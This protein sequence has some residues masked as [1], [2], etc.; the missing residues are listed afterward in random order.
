MTTP[1]SFGPQ[2]P[3]GNPGQPPY[4]P[5][6]SPSAAGQPGFG[7]A[8]PQP[9]F[10]PPSG[11]QPSSQPSYGQVPPGQPAFGQ[12]GP[13]QPGGQAPYGGP[14]GGAQPPAKKS[15]L[16]LLI[17]G[18]VAGVLVLALVAV[19][20]VPRLVGSNSERA[21][22]LAED[23]LTA[24]SAGKATE[25]RG[26]LESAPSDT[27]LLTDEVLAESVKKAPITE[28]K[29]SAPTSTT[30]DSSA[31][32]VP[33][34][35]KIGS[36][37]VTDSVKVVVN[38][39]KLSVRE[40]TVTL[41]LPSDVKGLTVLVNG[42]K[43]GDS[44]AVFPGT[45][46]VTTQEKY[47]T[48]GEK[49]TV[50]V[51]STALNRVRFTGS[52]SLSEEGTTIFR[53]KIIA[54]AEECLKSTQLKAGC[55]LDVPNVVSGKTMKEGSVTRSLSAEGRAT[56]ESLEPQLGSSRAYVVTVKGSMPAVETRVEATD[57]GSGTVTGGA[58]RFDKPSIDFSKEDLPI[59]WS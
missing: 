58:A 37:Q 30:R 27:S 49:G 54:A 55:G 34:T 13:G 44:P 36:K 20:V 3:F 31:F 22:K 9:P 12:P 14:S 33:V 11:S 29:A 15:K 8:A 48:F 56:L 6:G 57:G 7:P 46:T 18:G 25:A 32:T 39:A 43:P 53:E 5:G 50:V 21:R 59:T 40:G 52:P 35:Y 41:S 19:L 16:P 38:D 47:F 4:G 2:S 42:V 17:G 23:Y 51:E 45:Y 1:G 10:G 24:L 28:V 26:M